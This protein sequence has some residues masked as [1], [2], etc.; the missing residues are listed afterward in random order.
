M[1][2]VTE[3]PT[4]EDVR[5][6][7]FN[8]LKESSEVQKGLVRSLIDKMMLSNADGSDELVKV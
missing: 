2:Y 7:P 5:Q 8:S 4:V 3:L 6:Y 1:F